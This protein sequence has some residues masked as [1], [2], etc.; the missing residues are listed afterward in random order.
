MYFHFF[1][2]TPHRAVFIIADKK[3]L[4]CDG[5][6]FKFMQK[7]NLEES[8]NS[9]VKPYM[10]RFDGLTQIEVLLLFLFL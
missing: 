8:M 10:T 2:F 3:S 1:T 4:Y 6:K 7:L 5:I 9:A